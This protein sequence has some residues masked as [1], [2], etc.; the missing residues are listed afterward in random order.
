MVCGSPG[1]S[2]GKEEG[3]QGRKAGTDG[4]QGVWEEAEGKGDEKWVGE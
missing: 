2:R 4:E 1:K 3:N